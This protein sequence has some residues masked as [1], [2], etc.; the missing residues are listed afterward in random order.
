MY[1]LKSKEEFIRA[2]TGN[3]AVL[4]GFYEPDSDEGLVF[5]ES[6]KNLERVIDQRILVCKVNVKEHPEIGLGIYRTPTIRVYYK[7]E[8]VFEQV[9]CLST[10]ELNVKVLRRGIREVFNKRNINLRV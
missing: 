4:I 7:G 3:E 9:G 5:H 2:L 6:L 8:V 10:V 1:E